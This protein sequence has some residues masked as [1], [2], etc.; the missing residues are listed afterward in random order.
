MGAAH[1]RLSSGEQGA[2]PI[3]NLLENVEAYLQQT[4]G[5]LVTGSPRVA[6]LA[7]N[8]AL[9]RGAVAGYFPLEDGSLIFWYDSSKLRYVDMVEESYH[10]IDLK[11]GRWT[12]VGSDSPPALSQ[13]MGLEIRAKS[14]MI[15]NSG[16]L[17]TPRLRQALLND[18]EQAGAGRTALDGKEATMGNK[19]VYIVGVT[20]LPFA[21]ASMVFVSSLGS[22]VQKG[23]W[24]INSLTRKK[25][26]VTA[27]SGSN[28]RFSPPLLK[29]LQCADTWSFTPAM[30][31]DCIGG[32][33]TDED[34]AL[35]IRQFSVELEAVL[36]PEAVVPDA[37]IAVVA[38]SGQLGWPGVLILQDDLTTGQLH[39]ALPMGA[40]VDLDNISL[41]LLTD[42][43]GDGPA[44]WCKATQDRFAS[45][46][47]SAN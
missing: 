36:K 1:E 26:T 5:P 25:Y 24:L 42:A 34:A 20:P 44:F 7:G 39:L 10:F 4:G 40:K 23:D 21:G 22:P 47:A 3:I 11:G 13:N 2:H 28:I 37:P 46:A 41:I 33:L 14:M 29:H 17:M 32:F 31:P 30:G 12:L 15:E 18:I 8:P 45:S 9:P 19:L 27:M 16:H 43:L 38:Q 6:D 35:D